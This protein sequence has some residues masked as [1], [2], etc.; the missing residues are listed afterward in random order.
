[1]EK[2]EDKNYVYAEAFNGMTVRVP[3]D[4][5]DEWSQHQDDLKTGKA[6]PDKEWEDEVVRYILGISSKD[7]SDSRQADEEETDQTVT[8]YGQ[9]T[10]E[11]KSETPSDEE[12]GHGTLIGICVGLGMALLGLLLMEIGQIDVGLWLIQIGLLIFLF[13]VLYWIKHH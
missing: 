13:T 9:R 10:G 6:K 2:P 12:K 3:E 5:L 11:G 8:D 4:K 1:M 7:E